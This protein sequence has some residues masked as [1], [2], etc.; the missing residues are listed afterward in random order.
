MHKNIKDHKSLKLMIVDDEEEIREAYSDML[1]AYFSKIYFAENGFDALKILEKEKSIDHILVD[2]MM[3]EMDGYELVDRIYN[4]KINSFITV[5]TGLDLSQEKMDML[6]A[7]NILGVL[8]KPI[9]K[10]QLITHLACVDSTLNKRRKE[11]DGL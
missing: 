11:I 2:L 10:E 4:L 3:P 9:S 7:C 5:C 1:S 6:V 8:Y